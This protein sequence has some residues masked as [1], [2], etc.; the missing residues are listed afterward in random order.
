M[1]WET[2]TEHCCLGGCDMGVYTFPTERD[3][4]LFAALLQAAGY[5]PP[6]NIFYKKY[7]PAK[8]VKVC[9][10]AL[11]EVVMDEPALKCSSEVMQKISELEALLAQD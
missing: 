11:K 4:L 3:A 5:H 2:V 9:L 10:A 6:H 7:D 8:P 1:L